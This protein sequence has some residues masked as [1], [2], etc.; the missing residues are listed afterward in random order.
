MEMI[1][2]FNQKGEYVIDNKII[3]NNDNVLV[4]ESNIV[5]I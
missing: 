1:I 3:I 5:S 4:I 2:I